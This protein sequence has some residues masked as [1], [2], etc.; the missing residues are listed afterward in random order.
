MPGFF[1]EFTLSE[2]P[3]F[4]ATLRMTGEGLRMTGWPPKCR[5][6]N[7]SAQGPPLQRGER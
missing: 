1:A 3:G 7:G 4:F 5:K 6:L 2:M